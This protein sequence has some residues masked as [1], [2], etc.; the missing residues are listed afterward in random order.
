MV[1]MGARVTLVTPCGTQGEC[2]TWMA[3]ATQMLFE[4]GHP[5]VASGFWCVFFRKKENEKE[6]KVKKFV[7]QFGGIYL[8]LGAYHEYMYIYIHMFIYVLII[9]SSIYMICLIYSK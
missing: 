1:A 6:M 5:G 7:I 2:H 4:G 8:Y 9:Y 3:L